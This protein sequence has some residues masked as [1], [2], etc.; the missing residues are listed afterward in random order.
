M[1]FSF[2]IR[3]SRAVAGLALALVG[4]GDLAAQIKAD[5]T[6][7]T[8]DSVARR[9]AGTRIVGQRA[10]GSV[11]SAPRLVAG[12][13]TTG[14]RSEVV[15]VAG[16]TGN[17]AEKIGRQ[18]FAEVPGVFVYDMDGSGN[19]V[20]ISTRGLDAHRSWE[21]NV[22]QNGVGINSDVYGYPASH[23]SAPIEAVERVELVRGTAA[24][25]YG[26]QFGGLLNYVIRSPDTTRTFAFES[27]STTGSSGVW[28]TWNAVGG[29]VGRVSYYAYSSL[30]LS[31]GYR[32]NGK[33][34]SDAEYLSLSIPVS[35]TLVFRVE[36][37]RSVYLY[38]Q[39]GPLS[40]SAF[41][42]DPRSTTRAR[43][44]Y[45]PDIRV[46]SLTA[47][48]TPT[49]AT[50]VTLVASG[51]FGSRSSVAVGGFATQA[52]TPST[53]GVWSTRQVDIDRYD[54]RTLEVRA[55]HDARVAARTVTLSAGVALADNDLWRRQRGTGSRGRDYD[56]S[57]V[58]GTAFQR[59]LHYRSKNIAGYAEADVRVSP[60]W[61][62]VPGVRLEH[63]T[64]RMRGALAYY[65]PADTPRDIRHDFPLFGMR[66]SYR[67]PQDVEWYGGWSQAYRPMILKDV[68]PETATERTDP[69]I[70]DARGWTVESGLRGTLINRLSYDVGVFRMRYANR[71][72]LLTLTDSAGAPY[73][74]KTNV[75]TSI[76]SGVEARLSAPLGG[77]G[78][79]AWRAFT[80]GSYMNARYIAGSVSTG[81][82]NVSV[83]GNEVESAP[84]WIVR[85]G[86][87]ASTATASARAQL[88]HVSRTF[89][90][91]LNTVTP[92]AT[93]AVGVVPAYTLVDLSGG[94]SASRGLR[95]TGGV[96][97][98]FNHQYFTKRPQ[99]YPGPGVWPSDGRSVY[100]S[101]EIN[102][103]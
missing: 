32:R 85:T 89:A 52:D 103:R 30:R 50:R 79:V 99:F 17:A 44:W 87:T 98:L 88:S 37:G 21:F 70:R 36:A 86:L 9:L 6:R 24:L 22:R 56:L 39:P 64:T 14:A 34:A 92:N 94:W 72:G 81:G 60:R 96:S 38:R 62:V 19:Q 18:L 2:R 102:P 61:S 11:T 91:A 3:A 74:F 68:L 10:A 49:A 48:W 33:S 67:A 53:A 59:D 20:N 63:G 12:I 93:G 40:D 55:M 29:R 84:R 65:D 78:G 75:G 13:L 54:T 83:I 35:G 4:S 16:T 73:T 80:A 25:Q 41:E 66:S 42:L 76:T 27:R 43:N 26:S 47:T 51:V 101:L 45:S 8:R 71:F 28:S 1:P 97:N 46:P 90:D 100:V 7:T 5:S 31:D 58:P 82:R 95:V 69:G 15:A 77:A 23:Y 57:L